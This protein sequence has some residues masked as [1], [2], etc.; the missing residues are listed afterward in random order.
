M[1]SSIQE[2]IIPNS[3]VFHKILNSAKTKALLWSVLML[4]HKNFCTL[5]G[6]S[7]WLLWSQG[8]KDKICW[9]EMVWHTDRHMYWAAV[10]ALRNGFLR[11]PAAGCLNQSCLSCRVPRLLSYSYCLTAY[12][13]TIRA[14]H[15]TALSIK[16]KILSTNKKT[17]IKGMIQ[18]GCG[19]HQLLADGTLWNCFRLFGSLPTLRHHGSDHI[20]R[21][22]QPRDWLSPQ[23]VKQGEW[24]SR[25]CIPTRLNPIPGSAVHAARGVYTKARHRDLYC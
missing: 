20:G 23:S 16:T 18:I 1:S 21:K 6:L 10:C 8:T 13:A 4:Q 3:C 15:W 9:F 17:G 5:T 22:I 12:S 14:G 24:S 19:R 11:G 7:V 2:F 25:S